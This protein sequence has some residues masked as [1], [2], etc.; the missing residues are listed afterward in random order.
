MDGVTIK[1]LY[2]ATLNKTQSMDCLPDK[3]YGHCR[4]VAVNGGS[5]VCLEFSQ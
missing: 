5:T 2:R 3:T 4:E 1:I